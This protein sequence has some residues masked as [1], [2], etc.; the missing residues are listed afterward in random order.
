MT[1]FS[2]RSLISVTV[3]YVCT[4]AA[5]I[6]TGLYHSRSL[7]TL[8]WTISLGS[9]PQ[10]CHRWWMGFFFFSQPGITLSELLHSRTYT[11]P[12]RIQIGSAIGSSVLFT[13]PG[14]EPARIKHSL[15]LRWLRV[16][17][18][19]WGH[20]SP[21]KLRGEVGGVKTVN[22]RDKMS[23]TL[24]TNASR[25][26]LRCHKDSKKQGEVKDRWEIVETKK[27]KRERERRRRVQSTF[28]CRN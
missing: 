17:C 25:L 24:W 12:V 10:T 5:K 15:N 13:P 7:K 26:S 22:L 8:W 16:E 9:K 14:P 21:P 27:K 28:Q 6:L 23:V 18:G 2:A 19:L 20:R 3:T 4:V 11:N 1:S